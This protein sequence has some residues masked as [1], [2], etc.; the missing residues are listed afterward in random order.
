[1]KFTD[2]PKETL[3]I[4]SRV[5]TSSQSEDGVS[6]DVQEKRGL[7]FSKNMNLSPIV[8]KEQGSGMK[9][10][11]DT[12]PQFTEFFDGITDGRVKNIWIDEE[13]RLT[14]Y[15]LDLQFIHLE[16]KKSV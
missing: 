2:K 6:L 13:T 12:R 8:I 10:F 11:V 9:P 4:Y 1:M 5:S 16:M 3:Y 15:D 7:E 14:R